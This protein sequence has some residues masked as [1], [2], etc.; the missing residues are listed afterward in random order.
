[1]KKLMIALALATALTARAETVHYITLKFSQSTVTLDLRQHLKDAAATFEI[2]IPTTKRFYDSVN[3]GQEL[4][5]RLRTMPFY[6]N[7]GK[8]KV[9]VSRKFTREEGPKETAK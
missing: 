4:G 9:T 3:V 6:A 1:M 7:L 2:T 5:G 8:R